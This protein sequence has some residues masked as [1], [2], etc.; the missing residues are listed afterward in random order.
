[1]AS[2]NTSV[3]KANFQRTASFVGGGV[4]ALA[5]AA[6]AVFTYVYPAPDKST[7]PPAQTIVNSPGAVQQSTGGDNSPAVANV[8]GNVN[9]GSGTK[10]D[11]K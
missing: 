6:W 10:K 8:K 5:A 1:M 9:M 7:D 3:K 11:G 4:A 2:N